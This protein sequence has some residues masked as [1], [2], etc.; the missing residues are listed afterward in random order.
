LLSRRDFLRGSGLAAITPFAQTPGILRAPLARPQLPQG[1]AAGAIDGSTAVIWSRADRAARMVVE[2]ATTERFIGLR[3]IEGSNALETSDYTARAMLTDFKGG[4]RI[5]YRVLFQDLR[6]L[7]AWSEPVTGTFVT[8][9]AAGQQLR[10]VSLVWSADTA[11]QGWGINEEWG[12]M[13]LYETIRRAE[14]DLFIHAGDT[15][16]ADAVLPA[17]AKLD[18]GR[19]WRNVVTEA[20]SRVAQ[21]LDD[22]RGNYKYNLL[23]AHMRALNAAVLQTAIWDDHEVRDNWY[24][25]RD[26][27]RDD[28]Y[29]VKSMALLAERGRTA[30]LE[31]N[32][33]PPTPQ[34]SAPLYRRLSLGPLADVFVL[35]LRTHRGPNTNGQQPARST[36]TA[37]FGERQ[38][39]W[40]KTGLSGSKAVWK[41]IVSSMPIGLV[42]RDG[43]NAFEAM[44]NANNGAPL[45]RELD[46]ANLLSFLKQRRTR[47]VVWITGDVHYCAAHRYDPARARFTEFDPFWEFVAGPLHAGTFGP[48]ALD[49]TFG[50]DVKFSGVPEGMKP[51]R[52]P[53]DGLQFF[54]K[55]QVSARTRALTASLHNLEGRSLYSI[56]LPPE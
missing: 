38:L 3:R 13:R 48:N 24:P 27:S 40:L 39:H 15:I 14:P 36:E 16:Y 20:K 52:S 4:Q 31:Y 28:R 37:V 9:P 53:M 46:V 17:E 44:A 12:G 30:F 1:V 10:D 50:P 29:S 11:G 45:G 19:T 18:D 2:Y 49:A 43:E 33:L 51:N 8:F 32:A 34:R 35:D 41:V 54:G 5:F 22:Y 56:E 6:D 23:D 47:N 42:V 25:G 21:T 55:L 26:L 7:R